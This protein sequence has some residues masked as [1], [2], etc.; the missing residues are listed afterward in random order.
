VLVWPGRKNLPKAV[1]DLLG[2]P[3]QGEI[4]GMI[5]A[6]IREMA[7]ATDGLVEEWD[8]LNE[9]YTNHDLLDVFGRDIMLDWFRTA[10]EA[11][12]RVR[13]FYN[14]FSNH[15]LTTDADHVANTEA[16][17]QFLL[18]HGAPLGGLGI[19]AHI[20]EQPNAPAEVLKV[21]DRYDRFHLPIRVTEFDIQTTDEALQADYTRDFL[22]LMFSHPSVIGVQVWGFWEKAH[23]RPSAA[24]Y[25]GDWSEKPNGAAYR[26]LV[27][28]QWRTRL[29]GVTGGDG[30]FGGRGFFGDYTAWVKKGDRWMSAPFTVRAEGPDSVVTLTL[31]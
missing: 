9:P 11:M 28:D 3:R 21:L 5:R 1:Q 6:H 18:D 26:A 8:T 24:M 7:R 31:P 14:D 12:P 16:N 25:R 2:T 20:G 4:P 17:L 13:L 30:T 23:W 27:L 22:T 15:D 29:K 10:H 19:Q